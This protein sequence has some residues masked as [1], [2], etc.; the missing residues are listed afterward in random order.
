MKT[1]RML[2]GL[3]VVVTAIYLCWKIVPAYVSNYQLQEDMDDV[4]R[5]AAVDVKK[6]PDAI[7]QSVLKKAQEREMPID[8]EDI[9][10]VRTNGYV[11]ISA[12]YVVRVDV[13][14]YPFDMRFTPSTNREGLS[15][16]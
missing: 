3:F 16:R 15:F 5:M 11:A 14:I 7:K 2:F 9:T 10:V 1:L 6:G 12:D 4:A 13:P 8:A